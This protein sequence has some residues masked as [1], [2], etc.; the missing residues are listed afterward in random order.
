MFVQVALLQKGDCFVRIIAKFYVFIL[1]PCETK[2]VFFWWA[3][4]DSS[5]ETA[6]GKKSLFLDHAVFEL[7]VTNKEQFSS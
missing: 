3:N 7:N 5:V 4:E 1:L 6:V 2:V